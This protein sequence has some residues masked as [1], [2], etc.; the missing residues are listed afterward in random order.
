MAL[1]GRI[2]ATV[3][4]VNGASKASTVYYIPTQGS[5]FY[6]LSPTQTFNSIVCNSVVE[7]LPTGLRTGSTTYYCTETVAQLLTNGI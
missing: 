4:A 5:V 7:V 1:T 3:Q 6:P 2:V